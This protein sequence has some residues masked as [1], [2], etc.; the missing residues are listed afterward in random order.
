MFSKCS[1][2]IKSLYWWVAKKDSHDK[3]FA[4]MQY[5]FIRKE[6]EVVTTYNV[7]YRF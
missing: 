1:G 5:G 3:A 6:L 7:T 4:L 2:L